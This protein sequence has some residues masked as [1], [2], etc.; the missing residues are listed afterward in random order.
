MCAGRSIFRVLVALALVLA[1]RNAAG[2]EAEQPRA[3]AVAVLGVTSSPAKVS[4]VADL[5]R[6]MSRAAT[7]EKINIAEVEDL[8]V[9]SN[10]ALPE[11]EEE[12]IENLRRRAKEHV[13]TFEF[14][15]ARAD[16]NEARSLLLERYADVLCHR[17]LGEVDLELAGFLLDMSVQAG[18]SA[19]LEAYRILLEAARCHPDISPSPNDFGS[20][21]IAAWEQVQRGR[22]LPESVETP[23]VTLERCAQAADAAN[24][25][26]ALT[27][28]VLTGED[29]A[30]I[31][32][33]LVLVR[34][35]SREALAE[36][37]IALGNRTTWE[38]TLR[39]VIR[40]LFLP[41]R[42]RSP[43]QTPPAEPTGRILVLTNPAGATLEVDGNVVDDPTP[44]IVTVSPGAHILSL[45]LEGYETNELDVTAWALQTQPVEIRMSPIDGSIGR[46]LWW[47]WT[48]LG[49]ATVGAAA[50]LI[51]YGVRSSG[52]LPAAHINPTPMT[53]TV[54]HGSGRR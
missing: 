15:S 40:Q 54:S 29:D 19:E 16:L 23:I 12:R 5:A 45:S 25:R 7:A 27:G 38:R 50:G 18:E 22:E 3:P 8:V 10:I 37:T 11:E 43:A 32:L 47:V 44:T 36:T 2:E 34:A 30:P 48:L 41:L 14:D 35:D 9:Q 53:F 26:F 52:E 46:R 28:Q 49:A 6:A 51:V 1:S 17:Q 13:L 31:R 39:P 42:Q 21:L 24:I 4:I 20:R 33:R